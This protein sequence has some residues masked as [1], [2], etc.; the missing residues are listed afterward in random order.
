MSLEG[1]RLMVGLLYHG[2]VNL[3]TTILFPLFQKTQMP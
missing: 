1:L 3:R 2:K